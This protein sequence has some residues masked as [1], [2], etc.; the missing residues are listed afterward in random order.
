MLLF[1]L[2]VRF[3]DRR[4]IVPDRRGYHQLGEIRH[5]HAAAGRRAESDKLPSQTVFTSQCPK[6]DAARRED[7]AD[8]LTG[9]A[10]DAERLVLPLRPTPGRC[11]HG[12]VGMKHARGGKSLDFLARRLRQVLELA[13]GRHGPNGSASSLLTGTRQP[14]TVAAWV[15]F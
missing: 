15:G 4:R 2:T 10:P 5:L 7:A 9:D 11:R 12:S 3:T 8:D 14:V 13:Q 1:R 6:V